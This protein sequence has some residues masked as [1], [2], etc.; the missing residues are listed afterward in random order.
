LLNVYRP[1]PLL[2]SFLLLVGCSDEPQSPEVQLTQLIEAAEQAVEAR[3]LSAV[4]DYV[5]QDYRDA[6]HRDRS[7]LRGLLAGYFMRHPSIYVVSKIDRIDLPSQGEAKVVIFA[8]LAASAKAAAGPL[9][10]WRGNLLRLDLGFRFNS[11]GEWHLH[12]ASWRPARRE[13]FTQ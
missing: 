4:M 2:F 13:D 12:S 10:G 5:D 11:D 6:G 9:T 8:G 1:Y 7:Q 3:D